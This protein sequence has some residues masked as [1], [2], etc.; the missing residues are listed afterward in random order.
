MK[1]IQNKII[2]MKKTIFFLLTIIIS[3]SAFSQKINFNKYFENKTL[4]LDYTHAGNHDTA[5]I[6]FEQLKQEPFWGGSHVNLIDTFNYGQYKV[7]V[8]DKKT[9]KKI[10]SRGYSTLFQ[11]WQTS[12][13]ASK[14]N[15]SFYESVVMPFP[16]EPVTVSIEQINKQNKYHTIFSY[17]VNPSNMFIHKGLKYHFPTYNL[18]KN[19]DPSKKLDIVFLAEGYTKKQ[20]NK[21]KKDVKKFVNTLFSYE[22]FASHKKDINIH[23]VESYSPESGT[24]IPGDSI[25]E[26][27]ILNTHFWTFGTERYLTTSDYKTVRDIAALVPYDQ[28][29]ILVNTDK[30]GGGGIFNFYNLCVSDNPRAPEV[31]VH[32]FGHGFGGLADEY[33]Y[34]DDSDEARYDTTVEPPEPNITT[35]VNFASKWQD[36]ITKGVPIPTPAIEKYKN[37]VGAFEGAGYVKKGVYRPTQHCLMRSLDYKFCVVCNRAITKMLRFYSE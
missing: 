14:I 9:N 31:F 11:E 29:Y 8:R 27:T 30:Y 10:Y 5:M 6:F 13:E 4:R 20:M 1:L 23:V 18:I 21:Y 22:P 33:A 26:N 7:V 17:A 28:I 34:G 19:G 24:D 32:E 35:L 25:W 12:A 36:L 15:R 3:I 2:K 37:A 16:K